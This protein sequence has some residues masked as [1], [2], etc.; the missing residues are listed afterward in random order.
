MKGR[1]RNMV[2]QKMNHTLF[3]LL[4]CPLTSFES[5]PK[6]VDL[7]EEGAVDTLGLEIKSVLLLSQVLCLILDIPHFKGRPII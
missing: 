3:M 1:L 2:L 5:S 6:V 7:I 4:D